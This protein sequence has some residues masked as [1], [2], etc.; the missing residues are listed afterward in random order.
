MIR[1]IGILTFHRARNIG[2]CLQV[3]AL[4]TYLRTKEQDVE[5]INYCPQYIEDSFGVW[6]KELY[7][8]AKKNGKSL[9]Q[10]FV[11]SVI[12]FPYA[13]IREKNS[14]ISDVNFSSFQGEKWVQ[15][16]S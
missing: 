14:K 16:K 7:R 11:K 1:K 5:I 10:W 9:V 4:Q 3:Y 2:A 15:K 8:E 12:K 6:P 13:V